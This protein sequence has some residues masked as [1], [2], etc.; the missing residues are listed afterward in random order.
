[1]YPLWSEVRDTAAPMEDPRRS[2]EPTLADDAAAGRPPPPFCIFP[3]AS[4]E[5][6]RMAEGVAPVSISSASL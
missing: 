5:G 3:L 6:V 2:S 4:T 1:M